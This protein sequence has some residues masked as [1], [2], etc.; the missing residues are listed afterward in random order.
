V[1]LLGTIKDKKILDY[2]GG[3]GVLVLALKKLG[4]NVKLYDVSEEFR[5]Q[6]AEKIGE[7]N[8]YNSIE[9]IPKNEF[10]FIIFKLKK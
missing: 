6:A 3:P 2:G 1:P 10:D 7:K 5:K 9:E 8:V 4:A